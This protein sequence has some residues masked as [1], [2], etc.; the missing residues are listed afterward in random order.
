MLYAATI[1]PINM[2]HEIGHE[3]I[4]ISYGYQSWIWFDLDG[5]HQLCSGVPHN[6]LLYTTAGGFFGLAASLVLASTWFAFPKYVFFLIVGM[7]HALDHAAKIILEGFFYRTYMSGVAIEYLT[8]IQIGAFFGMLLLFGRMP[9]I[10][11]TV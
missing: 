11:K 10:I 8:A 3:W 6:F 5:G 1:I 2:V 7:S 9:R 4:C